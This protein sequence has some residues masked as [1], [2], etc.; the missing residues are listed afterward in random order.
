MA[1]EFDGLGNV[2]VRFVGEEKLYLVYEQPA[3]LRSDQVEWMVKMGH[4]VAEVL[5]QHR[6]TMINRLNKRETERVQENRCFR[7]KAV[8]FSA[9]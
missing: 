8:N 7:R 4:P 2:E 5:P 3:V 9:F 1:V 6:K